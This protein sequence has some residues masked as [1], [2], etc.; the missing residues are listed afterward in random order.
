MCHPEGNTLIN[1]RKGDIF[2]QDTQAY[3]NPVNSV[4]VMGKGLALQFK[5]HYPDM[6]LHYQNACRRGLVT[7]ARP[8]IYQLP[9]L[10]GPK[11]IINLA[12]KRHW[13]DK[14]RIL[15]IHTGLAALVEEINRLSITSIAIPAIGA[16]LG[17]IPWPEVVVAI[18]QHLSSLPATEV[19]I[20]EPY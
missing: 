6:F 4:G 1:Y 18:E 2:A 19:T 8:L 3:V 20:L 13:R 7:P 9:H 17:G 10:T 12:T 14:S 5:T 16:G 15:D 11:Y